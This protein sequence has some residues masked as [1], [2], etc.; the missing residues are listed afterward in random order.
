MPC[1][2][3][4]VL[5]FCCLLEMSILPFCRGIVFRCL[6]FL[7]FS[8]FGR[9][10]VLSFGGVVA[11]SLGRFSFGRVSVFSFCTSVV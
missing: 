6:V 8:H 3:F 7:S 11:L 2:C 4:V 1:C 9:V 5:S 10:V